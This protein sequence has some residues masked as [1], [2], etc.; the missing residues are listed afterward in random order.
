MEMLIPDRSKLVE[1]VNGRSNDRR[2]LDIFS[3][4]DVGGSDD[5]LSGTA[6]RTRTL[7]LEGGKW[8]RVKNMETVG[9]GVSDW[10]EYPLEGD[11]S[12]VGLPGEDTSLASTSME[13]WEGVV[14]RE[15]EGEARDSELP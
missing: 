1:E 2:D 9:V 5:F 4:G 11:I 7:L 8:P 13:S 10:L 12:P 14:A 3:I 6:G 15:A